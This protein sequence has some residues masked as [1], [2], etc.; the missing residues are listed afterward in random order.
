MAEAASIL[1]A[2]LPHILVL[3]FTGAIA[4]TLAGLLG[5]DGGA[6]RVPMTVITAPLGARLAHRLSRVWLRRA[7]ALFLAITAARMVPR[8]PG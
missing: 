5:V 2:F 7:F 1:V 6:L 8:L 4:G 3:L